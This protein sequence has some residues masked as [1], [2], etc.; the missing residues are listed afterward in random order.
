MAS[1]SV[2]VSVSRRRKTPPWRTDHR[3]AVAAAAAADGTTE[4]RLSAQRAVIEFG[5]GRLGVGVRD[6][7]GARG[8][9]EAHLAS[10]AR[11]PRLS[12]DSGRPRLLGWRSVAFETRPTPADGRALGQDRGVERVAGEVRPA[13]LARV[14]ALRGAEAGAD[15][16]V[17]TAGDDAAREADGLDCGVRAGAG[18]RVGVGVGAAEEVAEAEGRWLDA[19]VVRCAGAE[20]GEAR[21]GRHAVGRGGGRFVG[22]GISVFVFVFAFVFFVHVRQGGSG[23]GVGAGE[24]RVPSAGAEGQVVEA[25]GVFVLRQEGERGRGWF[26]RGAFESAVARRAQLREGG[27]GP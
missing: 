3:P 17:G 19:V 15:D 5:S 22:L 4:G 26:H 9:D 14:A 24:G 27:D 6:D 25:E 11:R 10:G 20:G 12:S 1:P 8:H 7:D 2:T 21:R 18:V 13:E 23:C 16:G